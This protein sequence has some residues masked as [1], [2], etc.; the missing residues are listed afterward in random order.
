MKKDEILKFFRHE[1]PQEAATEEP[2]ELDIIK[3]PYN[4]L[5]MVYSL[6]SSCAYLENEDLNKIWEKVCLKIL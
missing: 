3:I 5:N 6:N 1:Q 2:E 4:G